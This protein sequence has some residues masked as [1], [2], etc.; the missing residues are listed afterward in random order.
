MRKMINEM[1]GTQYEYFYIAGCI[2]QII[3]IKYI[4]IRA[5]FTCRLLQGVSLKGGNMMS[6]K[7]INALSYLEK[8]AAFLNIVA[9]AG[10]AVLALYGG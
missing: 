2:F 10:K 5:L 1:S 7:L 4:C 6:K 3:M 9:D 8:A